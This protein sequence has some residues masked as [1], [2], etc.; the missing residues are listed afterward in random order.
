MSELPDRRGFRALA[1]LVVCVLA[2]A[3]ALAW[4]LGQD[5]ARG[6]ADKR[7][8][9]VQVQGVIADTRP[10]LEALDR[11]RDDPSIAAVVVRVDSPGGSVGPSQEL[12]A[13][14]LELREEIPVVVSMGTVAA[15]GGYYIAS[16]GSHV[17]ANPGTLTGSIGVILQFADVSELAAWAKLRMETIKTGAYKDAG[18]AFRPLTDPERDYFQRLA[19]N[20]LEQFV[21]DVARGRAPAGIS[22][23]EVRAVAD[24]RVL[25]GEEAFAHGLVDELGGYRQALEVAAQLAGLDGR[26]EVF[27]PRLG[28]PWIQRILEE[29]VTVP[30]ST[31]LQW[32]NPL[33]VLWV[34]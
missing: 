14:L 1:I 26:P 22:E 10:Q 19:D 28:R 18:S 29:G 27:E 4:V 30:F 6:K 20:V 2:F 17:L 12:H 8:G 24:G 7:I 9:L 33:W 15:S 34:P 32:R 21:Q 25:T 31:E 3:A 5:G 11:L 13:A 23:P 16:A